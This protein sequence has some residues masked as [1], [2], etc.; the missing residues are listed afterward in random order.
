MINIPQ[1]EEEGLFI[2][3]DNQFI[4]DILYSI[5]FEQ[6]KDDLDLKS[7]IVISL[8]TGLYD[9]RRYTYSDVALSLNTTEEDIID[10][11]LVFIK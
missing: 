3:Y 9:G 4:L 1:V 7:K 5:G 10:K 11:K 2:N 8:L 6:I